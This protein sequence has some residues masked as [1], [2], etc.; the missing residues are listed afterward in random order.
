MASFE[1]KLN[2][3]CIRNCCLDEK[4]ICL[5]CHRSMLEILAWADADKNKRIEILVNCQKRQ[6]E[7]SKLKKLL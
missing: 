6:A 4:D 5:G 1:T 3:P 7:H 2:S